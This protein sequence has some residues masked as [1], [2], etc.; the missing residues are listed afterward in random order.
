MRAFLRALTTP[1]G[2]LWILSH[3]FV[4]LLGVVFLTAAPLHKFLGQGVSEG[5]GGSLIGV[6]DP[7]FELPVDLVSHKD[8]ALFSA[9]HQSA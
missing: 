4:V 1:V 7:R 8:A 2:I 9:G 3:S 5:V 6:H